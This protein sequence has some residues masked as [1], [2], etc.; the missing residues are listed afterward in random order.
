MC[1]IFDTFSEMMCDWQF[2][3]KN[4]YLFR[5]IQGAPNVQYRRFF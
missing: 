2:D 4:I 1:P 3:H 5:Q